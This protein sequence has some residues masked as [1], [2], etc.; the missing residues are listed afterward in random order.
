M[1][2]LGIVKLEPVAFLVFSR[3][4]DYNSLVLSPPDNVIPL[5]FWLIWMI[6]NLRDCF[7]RGPDPQSVQPTVFLLLPWLIHDQI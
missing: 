2:V 6:F 7:K 3:S 1:P 5:I 4:L